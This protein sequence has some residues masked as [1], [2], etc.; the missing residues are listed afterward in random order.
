MVRRRTASPKASAPVR[1]R[2][3]QSSYAAPPSRPAAAAPPAPTP[4]AG[5]GFHAPPPGAAPSQGPGL[6][7]QMAAT[8]GGVAIGSAVGHAVGNMFTGGSNHEAAP[9]PAQAAAPPAAYNNQ[10]LQNACEIEW[11]QFLEC[12]QNQSDLSLCSSYN[13]LFK[14]CKARYGA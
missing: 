1:S 2:S 11:R 6:M 7:G 9:A 3:P 8:A 10:P 4:A 5:P 14:Q 12:S 13:D